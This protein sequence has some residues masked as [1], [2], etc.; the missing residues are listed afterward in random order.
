MNDFPM[1]KACE[2]EYRDPQDRRYHGQTNACPV[3]GPSC[4]SVNEA[5]QTTARGSEAIEQIAI[6]IRLGKIAAVKGLGGYQF[7]CDATQDEAVAR[8]RQ[9]KHRPRKPLPIMVRDA[10]CCQMLA[11]LNDV[12]MATLCDKSN[13]IVL[14]RSKFH[15]SLSQHLHPGLVDIGIMLPTT[16]LHWLLTAVVDRPIVVTSGNL[17]GTPIAYRNEQAMSSLAGV[18]DVWLHHDRPII[19][20]VDDSV[21]RCSGGNPI[22]IRAAR[23]IA[24]LTLSESQAPG[25]LAVGGQQKCAVAI[26]TGKHLILGPH[27]GD[28]DSE[29]T[30]ARF[31][32]EAEQFCSL[33]GVSPVRLACDAHPDYFT[34][35]WANQSGKAVV[36]V[37][38]HHAHVVAAMLDHGLRHETVLGFAFDGTGYGSDATV[39]GGE[40]LLASASD[41][42]RVARLRSFSLPGGEVAIQQPWRVAMALLSQACQPQV[43]EDWLTRFQQSGHGPAMRY[44][45]RSGPRTTSIGRLFDAVAAMVLSPLSVSYEGEPAM[46]LE[47]A[48]DRSESSS[49]EFRLTKRDGLTMDWRP[50]IQAIVTDLNTLTP[51]RIAMKFHRSVA[52]VVL[53]VAEYYRNYPIVLSGG[54]FQNRLLTELIQESTSTAGLDFHFPGRVPINDGGLAIGQLAIA[55]SHDR[56]HNGDAIPQTEQG[57]HR[58]CV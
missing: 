35:L 38:H 34:N 56:L 13:P 24:P 55:G 46:L 2:A 39:W 53:A 28:L 32:T 4:W 31:Q 50:I 1:C 47:A 16:P 5:G 44:A 37:Q 22:T 29:A 11:H 54:V 40:V 21:V 42:Q 48:C 9:R 20:P 36:R 17:P 58:S 12:E 10:D 14:L 8:L 15:V 26:S 57:D 27:V 45:I 6:A 33:Y 43:S 51:A 18:A 25:T 7:I 41:F 23:G 49:Y 52:A 19:R 3:C 30:R